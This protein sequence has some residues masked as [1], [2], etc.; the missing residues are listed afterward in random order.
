[1]SI[2]FT[3]QSITIQPEDIREKFPG[4]IGVVNSYLLKKKKYKR[5]KTRKKILAG[6][7]ITEIIDSIET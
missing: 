4:L 2:E 3:I 5:R 6:D 1:M 7:L